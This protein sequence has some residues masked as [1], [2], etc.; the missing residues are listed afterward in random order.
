MY[1]V[2]FK[3]TVEIYDNLLLCGRARRANTLN[4]YLRKKLKGYRNTNSVYTHKYCKSF[5][6]CKETKLDSNNIEEYNRLVEEFKEM[7]NIE[8]NKIIKYTDVSVCG[9]MCIYSNKWFDKNKKSHKDIRNLYEDNGAVMPD[10]NTILRHHCEVKYYD[11]ET[12]V[13][14]SYFDGYDSIYEE[15][16]T[17]RSLTIYDSFDRGI[18]YG[19]FGR[20]EIINGFNPQYKVGDIVE[21]D[22][23]RI[24]IISTVPEASEGCGGNYIDT[25]Y[26]IDYLSYNQYLW[27]DHA[28]D[29]RECD[30]KPYTGEVPEFIKLLQKAILEQDG[31]KLTDQIRCD[32]D[33]LI[34]NYQDVV[35]DFD[36]FKDRLIELLTA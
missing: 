17:D 27:A 2:I 21:Y 15:L 18:S 7:V 11:P 24:A 10:Y 25:L 13:M 12:E 30:F 28:Y 23:D 33:T 9:Y 1:N 36:K 35:A 5:Y 29:I 4:K 3:V 31:Y 16:S 8:Y 34:E 26:N 20:E 14:K 32:I 19:Y 6:L 22:N